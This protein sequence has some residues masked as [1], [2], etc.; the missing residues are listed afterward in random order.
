ML[1]FRGSISLRNWV[2]NLDFNLDDQCEKDLGYDGCQ[3]HAGFLDAWQ[4]N[5]IVVTFMIE[6]ALTQYPSYKLIVT[7]H[8]L[9]GA[10]A[11]VAAAYLRKAG[12]ACDLY[13]YG[14]PRV[15][16][17][18]FVQYMMT[19]ST[20]P[21]NNGSSSHNY[22]ITHYDDPVPRL[23]PTTW[24]LGSF[25][26]ISPEYWLKSENALNASVAD[27][28]VCK[29]TKND[30]CNAGTGGLDITAHKQYFGYLS[31]CGDISYQ[32]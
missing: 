26:H 17:E 11:T 27:F 15:G 4:N 8:S 12:H 6:T 21:V 2:A 19:T 32:L 29:G 10:T 5:D 20:V 1:A 9:G 3:I 13:T 25:R 30:N 7:G 31:A 28:K 23:P 22:R 16:N 24:F 14:S 18:Q